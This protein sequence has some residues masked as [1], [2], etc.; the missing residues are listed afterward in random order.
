MNNPYP[1]RDQLRREAVAVSR[2]LGDRLR[3][4]VL[5]QILR[6]TI[7]KVGTVSEIEHPD[8]N[9]SVCELIGDLGGLLTNIDGIADLLRGATVIEE[10]A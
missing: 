6:E 8:A 2:D 9:Y 4:S 10:D 3:V 5:E 1:T 7:A